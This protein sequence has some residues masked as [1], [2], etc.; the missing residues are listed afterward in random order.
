MCTAPAAKHPW[1][2]KIA[3]ALAQYVRSVG[4]AAVILLM[5]SLPGW[6]RR[7]AG[8]ALGADRLLRTPPHVQVRTVVTLL[9][10]GVNRRDSET[11]IFSTAHSQ[12]AFGKLC[13]DVARPEPDQGAP[14]HPSGLHE[15]RADRELLLTTPGI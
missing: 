14:R 13:R 2:A 8:W 12:G 3:P 10:A 5:S 9:W 4:L 1:L 15:D 11:L 7:S 6:V